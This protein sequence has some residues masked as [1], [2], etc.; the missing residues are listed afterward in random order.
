M[1]S[2]LGAATNIGRLPDLHVLISCSV[3]LACGER[4]KDEGCEN[5]F[6]EAKM[7]YGDIN[8]WLQNKLEEQLFLS[9]KAMVSVPRHI[10]H[11]ISFRPSLG[12]ICRQLSWDSRAIWPLALRDSFLDKIL[13]VVLR[14]GARVKRNENFHILKVQW[15]P[16]LVCYISGRRKKSI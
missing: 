10:S 16:P 6:Q 9:F 3:R 14:N 15:P 13:S 2:W 11:F 4:E 5:G 7:C 12:F 1:A 8:G